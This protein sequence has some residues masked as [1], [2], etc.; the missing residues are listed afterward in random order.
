MLAQQPAGRSLSYEHGGGRYPLLGMTVGDVLDNAVRRFPEREA[1]IVPE[2]GIR[3]TWSELQMRA[4]AFA[5]GLLALGLSPGRHGMCRTDSRKH[6][7]RLSRPGARIRIKQ[8]GLPGTDH[9][10]RIQ[11]Q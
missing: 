8:G 7:S 6:Q 1:L 4:H 11:E 2:Q 9:R 10:D 3:W 5:A